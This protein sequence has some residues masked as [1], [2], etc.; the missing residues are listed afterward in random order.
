L[1]G[2]GIETT[3]REIVGAEEKTEFLFFVAV[4]D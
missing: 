1:P 3:F 2:S 4:T